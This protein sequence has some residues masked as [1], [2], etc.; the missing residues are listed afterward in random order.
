LQDFYTV[1]PDFCKYQYQTTP[2]SSS[3]TKPDKRFIKIDTHTIVPG[4]YQLTIN[5][6][7]R[8]TTILIEDAVSLSIVVI[9]YNKEDCSNAALQWKG[10]TSIKLSK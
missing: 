1:S 4:T 2:T 5:P 3:I 7:Q 6:L 9:D 8:G 10:M